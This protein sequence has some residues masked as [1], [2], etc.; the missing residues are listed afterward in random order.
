MCLSL[1]KVC[2]QTTYLLGQSNGV[3][4]TVYY[5]QTFRQFDANVTVYNYAPNSARVTLCVDFEGDSYFNCDNFTNQHE[6]F[7]GAGQS[8]TFRYWGFNADQIVRYTVYQ[9]NV[10]G[11]SPNYIFADQSGYTHYPYGYYNGAPTPFL[12]DNTT[13]ALELERQRERKQKKRPH[14]IYRKFARWKNTNCAT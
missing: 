14:H 1:N 5:T 12:Y 4:A 8:R 7:L 2:A 6:F 9:F 13:N 3:R 11:G 10:E